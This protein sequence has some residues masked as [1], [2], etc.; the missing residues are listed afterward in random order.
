M[1]SESFTR[2]LE[3]AGQN[4]FFTHTIVGE[5]PIGGLGVGPILA[6]PRNTSANAVGQLLKKF[7]K[8]LAVPYVFEPAIRKLLID[9][10]V[11]PGSRGAEI[12]LSTP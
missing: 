2:G 12:L 1:G 5:E 4:L 6:D 7:S 3:M 9:P 11:A 8:P 10:S